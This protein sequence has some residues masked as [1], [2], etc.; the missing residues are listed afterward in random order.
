MDSRIAVICVVLAAFAVDQ[1]IGA[2]Q[3]DSAVSGD[4]Y[5]T[6]YDNIDIEQVL[7]SKRLVNSYVQCLLDKKPCTPEGT[8]LRST[9]LFFHTFAEEIQRLLH[10]SKNLS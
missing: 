6:K 7:A 10:F 1:T 4:V 2:P 5:T 3:K 9:Y 8:E